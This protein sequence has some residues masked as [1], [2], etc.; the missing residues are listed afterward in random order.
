MF[1]AMHVLLSEV[2]G[3]R[4]SVFVLVKRRA[5]ARFIAAVSAFFLF[6]SVD[7]P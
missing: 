3:F 7:V 1:C 6:F 2:F 4:C 5:L